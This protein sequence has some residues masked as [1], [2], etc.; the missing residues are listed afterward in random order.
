MMDSSTV[1]KYQM[2]MFKIFGLRPSDPSSVL[3]FIWSFIVFVLAGLGLVISQGIAMLFA[4]SLND[5]IEQLLLFLTTSTVSLKMIVFYFNKK[6]LTKALL[7]LREADGNL[8]THQDFDMMNDVHKICSR[9]TIFYTCVYCGTISSMFCQLPFLAKEE[10][11]WKST[12]LLPYQCAKDPRVYYGVL[13]FQAIGNS[14]NCAISWAI[15]TYG[16]LLTLLLS[17]HF[18]VLGSHFAHFDSNL[19]QVRLIDCLKYYE[20]INE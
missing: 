15:D 3:L 8:K 20:Q 12:S 13:I 11:T 5:F 6:S 10:L 17:K 7:M 4:S 14:M 16:L 19:G 18:E 9:I 2:K 1:I